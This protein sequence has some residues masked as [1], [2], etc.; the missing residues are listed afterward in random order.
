[1]QQKKKATELS[2]TFIKKIRTMR[3]PFELLES[4]SNSGYDVDS[5][6]KNMCYEEVT[7]VIMITELLLRCTLMSKDKADTY[8]KALEV[9]KNTRR[10]FIERN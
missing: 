1:M 5:F 3:T 2:N 9:F 6:L 4:F 10:E 8:R 7:M